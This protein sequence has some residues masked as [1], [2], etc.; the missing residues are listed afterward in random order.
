MITVVFKLDDLNATKLDAA[1][2][3]LGLPRSNFVRMVIIEHLADS[4]ARQAE[5]KA[6][7]AAQQAAAEAAAKLAV[8][9]ANTQAKIALA[10]AKA[11][12]RPLSV[13]EQRAQA[14]AAIQAERL[15]QITI[16]THD[17]YQRG[18][19]YTRSGEPLTAEECIAWCHSMATSE[20]DRPVPE[21]EPEVPPP[22]PPPPAHVL[23]FIKKHKPPAS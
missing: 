13:R 23:A 17:W 21:P 1:A 12:L 14:H 5:A 6:A 11:A 19:V 2:Q 10:K 20:F 9:E 16:N 22:L 18:H 7:A 8:I 15:K 4:P 3:Q